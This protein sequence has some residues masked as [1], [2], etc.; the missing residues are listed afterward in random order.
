[1]ANT[2][3]EV[4]LLEQRIAALDNK[5]FMQ[6]RE[7]FV[8]FEQNRWRVKS[9]IDVSLCSPETLSHQT[10]NEIE[11]PEWHGQILAERKRLVESGEVGFSDWETAKQEIQNRIR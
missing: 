2:L 6:L 1:M 3:N 9:A 10:P 8:E 7:W 11:P 4:E 5:A